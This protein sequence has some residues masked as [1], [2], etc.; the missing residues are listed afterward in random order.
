MEEWGVREAP[1]VLPAPGWMLLMMV[2][3]LEQQA[4]HLTAA[5]RHL[6]LLH[7]AGR[8]EGSTLR[9]TVLPPGFHIP[10]AKVH[11][12]Q[13][14]GTAGWRRS[15]ATAQHVRRLHTETSE[16][17]KSGVL[18]SLCFIGMNVLSGAKKRDRWL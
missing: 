4:Q 15:P 10:K 12:D 8:A 5:W 11:R 1:S 2:R 17:T 18:P 6:V 13:Q 16:D 14:A 9:P 3:L 7:R